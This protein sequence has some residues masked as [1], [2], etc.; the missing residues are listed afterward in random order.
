MSDSLSG[1]ILLSSLLPF[2]HLQPE[3]FPTRHR[4]ISGLLVS[5]PV[6][7]RVHQVMMLDSYFISFVS[8][9]ELRE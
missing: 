5:F 1:K 7:G 4:T 9:L 6:E 2:L 8:L 3:L